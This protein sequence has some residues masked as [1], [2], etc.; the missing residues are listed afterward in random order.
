MHSLT[1]P[2]QLCSCF[3]NTAEH[4]RHF[5]DLLVHVSTI[6]YSLAAN[7]YKFSSPVGSCHTPQVLP[8][9]SV[10]PFSYLPVVLF[11]GLMSLGF[12]F[13]LSC[14]FAHGD[15]GFKKG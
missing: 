4:K 1:K 11:H 2:R 10:A 7:P 5:W 9:T 6:S 13:N 15:Q 8:Y 12:V 14:E 3:A